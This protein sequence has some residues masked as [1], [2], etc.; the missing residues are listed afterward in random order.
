MRNTITV[1]RRDLAAYFT[2]PIAYIYMMVFVTLNVWLYVTGLFSGPVIAIDMSPFF[3]YIPLVLCVFVPA[4]TMRM[5]AEERKENTWEMLLTFPMRAHELVL[6]KYFAAIVFFG[7]TLVAT[8]TVPAMLAWL[9]NPDWGVI[10]GGYLGTAFVG[11]MFFALG[12]FF[13]G[14]FKDQII[15]FVITLLACFI[16]FLCGTDFIAGYLDNKIAGFGTL[17]MSLLGVFTHFTP[18]TRGVVDVVDLV[19]FVGWSAIFLGLNMLYIDGRSRPKAKLNFAV[20]TLLCAAIGMLLN[21]LA[22]GSSLKRFDLTEDRINTVAE[23]STEILH[24]LDSKVT[25]TLYITPRD[26]MP[27]ELKRLEESILDRLEELRLASNG[28]LQYKTVYL[29]AE[30]LISAMSS[31]FAPEEDKDEEKTEEKKVEERMLEKGITPIAYAGSTGVQATQ[32]MI[33]ASL[34]IAYADKPEEIIPAVVPQRR[35]ERLPPDFEYRLISTIYKLQRATTPVIALVAP[36][37]A[38]NVDPQ[39]RAMMESMGQRMPP[40]FYEDPFADLEQL[41]R[42]F[43]YEVRRV[44]LTKEEPLPDEYD[45][46]VVVNPRSLNE[47]QQWEIGRALRAGKTV[48]MA[49]QNYTWNYDVS[50]Q[51]RLN[52]S[53]GEETPQANPLLE[54][55]GVTVSEDLLLDES[56]LPLTYMFGNGTLQ[57]FDTPLQIFVQSETMDQKSPITDNLPGLLYLWGTALN[58]N[59]EKLKELGLQS[60]VLM[61]SSGRSWT[62]PASAMG[63]NMRFDPPDSGSMQSF[64]LLAEISGQFPD[65]F[66]GKERPAWPET[67]PDPSR[68]VPPPEPEEE[69]PAPDVTPKPGRLILIGCSQAF[70]KNNLNDMNAEF[71]LKMVDT[72]TLSK[73]VAELRSRVPMPRTVRKPENADDPKYRAYVVWQVVNYGLANLLIAGAG[74][75]FALVRHSS[76][77]AYT[78]KYASAP[79]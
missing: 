51:G 71:F 44:A 28:N 40:Q 23:A 50:R 33:Y 5:W 56:R 61:S 63:E 78:M 60:Q 52:L 67:P 17:L 21:W 69:G 31:Q 8:I 35:G 73:Q 46:L 14:F 19:Y 30:N 6:G 49:V 66:A 37:T 34:G 77:N 39:Q 70:Q 47:R 54:N 48:V 18:F 29:E 79:K 11:A 74:F 68:P 16:M 57:R 3:D 2:S 41:L 4:V 53:R 9:G 43:K 32:A 38:F 42:Q 65:A 22:A 75:A 7:L 10:L 55:Y 76:R 20:V 62:I 15:A 72:A 12:I 1:F 27:T 45:T 25:A 26:K 36:D 24:G 59:T 64:P 58:L 13:S